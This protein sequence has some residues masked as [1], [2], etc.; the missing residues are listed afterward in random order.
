MNTFVVISMALVGVEIKD[1]WKK[2]GAQND[3]V[4]TTAH[5]IGRRPIIC[6]STAIWFRKYQI[7]MTQINFSRQKKTYNVMQT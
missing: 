6:C 5:D 1:F 2:G 4:D 3:L 7:L